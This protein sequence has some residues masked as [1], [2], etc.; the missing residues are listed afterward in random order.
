MSR[1]SRSLKVSLLSLKVPEFLDEGLLEAE[2]PCFKCWVADE[3]DDAI[4]SEV[5]EGGL[6]DSWFESACEFLMTG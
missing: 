1:I 3:V 2:F 6:E 5:L 4:L